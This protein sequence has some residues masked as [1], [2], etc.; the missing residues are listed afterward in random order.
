MLKLFT[1]KLSEA[2][3]DCHHIH[4]VSVLFARTGLVTDLSKFYLLPKRTLKIAH[5]RERKTNQN[6]NKVTY[7][8]KKRFM[9]L[10]VAKPFAT[11]EMQLLL[12][13]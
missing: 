11:A 7:E 8:D 5:K 12:L 2:N 9:T 4:C 6:E 3:R 13:R 1:S 10:C